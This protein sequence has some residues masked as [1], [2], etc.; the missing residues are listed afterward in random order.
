MNKT[1]SPTYVKFDYIHVD[2]VKI[3]TS[4]SAEEEEAAKKMSGKIKMS[5]FFHHLKFCALLAVVRVDGAP[6][7]AVVVCVNVEKPM[8][9]ELMWRYNLKEL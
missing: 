9:T 1:T 6:E 5:F 2:Q 8:C 7:T 4:R 3:A